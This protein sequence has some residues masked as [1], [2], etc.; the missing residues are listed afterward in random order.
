MAPSLRFGVAYD[1]RNP[2]DS[3]LPMPHL[4]SQVLDQASAAEQL[5]YDMIWFT[6]HH[7]VEDGYLPSWIPVAGAVA[8]RTQRLRIST[9]IALLP[10]Y[11]PLRLA[12]DLAVLDNLSG[13]RI[14][15]GVGVGYAPHEFAGFGIPV[16]RRVSLTEE[17]LDILRLAWS[18]ERFS[19]HGKRYDVDDVAVTPAPVQPG[20]PPL[21]MGSMTEAGARRAA[22]YGLNMLPQGKRSASLDVWRKELRAAGENPDER[23]VGI[24][25]SFLVTDDRERDWPPV[26]T[27]ERYRM[28]VYA[29]FFREANTSFTTG[30]A[31]D[32]PQSWVVGDSEHV[33]R[34]LSAFIEE[35][36]FTDLITWGAP[37][38]IPPERMTP[39]LERFAREVMPRLRERFG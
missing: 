35:Y 3:G 29:R 21:W 39:N 8:A 4:Y 15:M 24:I 37:P 16:S 13:G 1:F 6:E 32:I 12:E 2:P 9:D 33:Y 5:G 10:F 31:D 22:R 27:A 26:R 17:G 20:G 34:E 7:F 14:E 11:Q 28:E 18:G 38:G 23:R 30:G 19:Y 36:G 25:R